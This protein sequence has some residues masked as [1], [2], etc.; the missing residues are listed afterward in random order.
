M[1]RVGMRRAV[2][3]GL[4]S[5]VLVVAELVPAAASSPLIKGLENRWS[6]ASVTVSRGGTV[7]WKGA[8]L[9]HNVYS[10]GSNWSLA[11]QLPEGTVVKH[12]FARRG[13]FRFRC[14]LHSTLVSGVCSGMCGTVRVT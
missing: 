10:Y 13:T 5:A 2:V 3:V 11:V 6:P 1:D 9:L 12:R 8:K 7:R 14:T 4:L